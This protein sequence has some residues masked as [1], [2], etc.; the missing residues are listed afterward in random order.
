MSGAIARGPY[1]R[2]LLALAAL[3]MLLTAASSRAQTAWRPT[4]PVELIAPSAAGGGTDLTARL[5]QRIIQ[6]RRLADVP[7]S[8]VNK[9]GGGG[10]VALTYLQQHPGDAHYLEAVSAVLLTNHIAGRSALSH[11]DFTPIALLNSE[12]VVLAV[13]SDSPIRAVKD[14]AARLKQDPGS[15][16]IAVGTSLGGV[17][18]VAIAGV[19]RAAGADPR[20][21]KAVV[22]KSSAESAVSVLGGHVDVMVSSASLVLPH[23]KSGALRALAIS[24]PKRLAGALGAVPTLREQGVD[25]VVDNFRVMI[26][27]SALSAAQLG[28]WDQVMG[29]LVQTD[30]WKKDLET[31]LWENTYMNSVNTRAYLAEEYAQMKSALTDLGLAK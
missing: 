29:R 14:L 23:L 21:L 9:P 13:K 26:G 6:E 30:D 4:K 20:R 2:A 22:F 1:S 10:S 5:M 8:V 11:S 27:P 12:Y 15:V 18:H 17:N 19:A 7:V 31:N 24:S 16:S 28:Y 3:G 25:T